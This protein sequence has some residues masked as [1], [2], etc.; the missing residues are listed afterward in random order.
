MGAV[1][2]GGLYGGGGGGRLSRWSFWRCGGFLSLAGG[3]RQRE[4]QREQGDGGD[5]P[6]AM[7]R[8]HEFHAF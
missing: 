5:K 1:L 2:S 4:R 3:Q 8:H 6:E 7:R